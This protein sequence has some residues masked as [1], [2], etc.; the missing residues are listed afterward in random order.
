MLPST[1][2]FI[3]YA[4]ISVEYPEIRNY[5]GEVMSD[6][7]NSRELRESSNPQASKQRDSGVLGNSLNR[8][9]VQKLQRDGRTPFSEIAQDLGVSEGTIRNRIGAMKAAG[10][11]RIV[12]VTD[13][14]ASE[15]RTEAMIGLRVAAGHRPEIVAKRLSGLDEIVYVVWVSGNYDLLVEVVTDDRQ[16]FLNILSEHI[17]GAK[18]IGSAEVMTGLVNFKNQFLLKSSWG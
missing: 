15:Y 4:A 8:E 6:K 13:S 18:D 16:A 2:K 14:G 17:H 5:D 7:G 10:H 11:L 12:A 1:E 9:I 3:A